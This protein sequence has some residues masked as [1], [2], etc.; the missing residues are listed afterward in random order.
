MIEDLLGGGAAVHAAR[1]AEARTNRGLWIVD[2]T[3]FLKK[4]VPNNLFG[5]YGL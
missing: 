3:G 2:D 1:H 4:G 5:R